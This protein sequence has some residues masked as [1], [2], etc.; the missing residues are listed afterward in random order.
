M[1]HSMEYYIAFH[2]VTSA[3]AIREA[4]VETYGIDSHRV[5]AGTADGLETMLREEH[6][7]FPLVT[8]LQEADSNDEFDCRLE[9][10][11]DLSE[12]I[13]GVDQLHLA[14]ELSQKL[15]VKALLEDPEAA[16][17]EWVLVTP[18]RWFGPV[19]LDEADEVDA[20]T[21]LA[22][23][24]QPVPFDAT[25]PVEPPPDWYTGPLPVSGF[26]P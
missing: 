9:A 3:E 17:T 15:K 6:S 19:V 20:G 25:I 7:K 24:F 4:L 22:S 14:V 11:D 23:A 26:L 2:K 16:P 18:D 13:G 21:K 10:H 12:A 5:F 8:I 1:H